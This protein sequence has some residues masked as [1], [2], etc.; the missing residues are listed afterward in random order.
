MDFGSQE[1]L[2]F[3]NQI[4]NVNNIGLGIYT[5]ASGDVNVTALGTIN[6]DSSRIATFDGGNIIH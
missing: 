3:E 4:M 6:V 2:P 1:L 5:T